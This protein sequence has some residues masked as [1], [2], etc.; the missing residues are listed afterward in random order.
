MSLKLFSFLL[1]ALGALAVEAAAQTTELP[2]LNPQGPSTYF[3]NQ[4]H[5]IYRQP[6]LIPGG[7][8]I[9]WGHHQGPIFEMPSADPQGSSWYFDHQGNLIRRQ[10][11]LIPGGSAMHWGAPTKIPTS[12][13]SPAFWFGY[14]LVR[15][16]QALW[17]SEPHELAQSSKPL[18]QELGKTPTLPQKV[19]ADA[20]RQ[21]KPA[22]SVAL[23]GQSTVMVE[24]EYEDG[25]RETVPM[26]LED[27]CSLF[28]LKIPEIP[29]DV[30]RTSRCANVINPE[31]GLTY[32]SEPLQR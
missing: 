32:G 22:S 14:W 6:S 15:G 4:G 2:S 31:T 12:D 30:F 10:P 27:V 21:S 5:L 23:S 17:F 13:G 19:E 18:I 25:R 29:K 16:V 11:S 28:S 24:L 7:G 8:A 3:D 1:G 20:M 26:T 9:Q